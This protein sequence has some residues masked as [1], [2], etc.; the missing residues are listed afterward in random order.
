MILF[1]VF[2]EPS[3]APVNGIFEYCSTNLSEFNIQNVN[4]EFEYCSTNINDF[5]LPP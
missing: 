4:D 5:P 3:G 1:Y 2:D